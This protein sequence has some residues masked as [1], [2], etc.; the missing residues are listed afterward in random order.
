MKRFWTYIGWFGTQPIIVFRFLFGMHYFQEMMIDHLKAVT[1]ITNIG[2]RVK[3]NY[4]RK[5]NN[6]PPTGDISSGADA[7]DRRL[8]RLAK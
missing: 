5:Q 2:V 8:D 7:Y 1:N 3:I 6:Y 4:F